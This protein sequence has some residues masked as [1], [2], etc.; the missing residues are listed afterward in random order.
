MEPAWREDGQELFFLSAD[1]MLMATEMK[2][3]AQVLSASIPRPLFVAVGAN[4]FA[5]TADGKRF[6]VQAS[7]Q[8]RESDSINVVL[9]W[10]MD[11]GR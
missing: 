4:Y 5:A 3:N 2:A 10:P 8:E 11:L 1:G 6:L 7:P 9:N